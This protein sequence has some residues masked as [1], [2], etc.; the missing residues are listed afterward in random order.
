ME[1]IKSVTSSIKTEYHPD[2]DYVRKSGPQWSISGRNFPP[3]MKKASPAPNQYK[4]EIA[5]TRFKNAPKITMGVKY[6]DYCS[7]GYFPSGDENQI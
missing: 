6:S 5:T 3:N 4:P 2:F 7:T 1:N